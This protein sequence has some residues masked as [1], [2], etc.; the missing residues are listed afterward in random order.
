MDRLRALEARTSTMVEHLGAFVAAESPSADTEATAACAALVGSVGSELLG[1]EPTPHRVDGRTHLLWRFGSTTRVLLIGHLDTVWPLGT[2]DRWPYS[3]DDGRATGPGA[4]DMKSGI[5]QALHGLSTLADL[6]GLSLLITS[7]EEL[8]SQTSSSLI[9]ELAA[10]AEA[11][12]ILEPA[13][14]GALK[15]G[16]KGVSMYTIEIEGRA[17]HAGLEPEAGASAVVELAHQVLALGAIED[18]AA[19]TTVTPTVAS[20]GTAMNVVPANARV[21][22]DVRAPTVAEQDRV[23]RL[24][25]AL[26]PTVPGTTVRVLGEPNRPPL[27]QTSSS[28]L[29]AL[30]RRIASALG[31]GDL[32]G[33]TVGGGSDGNFTASM[34]CRTLDGLGGV[35]AGAHAEGEYVEVA[36]MAP[37]A[38]LLA[39]LA[40]ELLA[41]GP[42]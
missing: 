36:Q 39:A 28:D 18:R 2:I 27:E 10:G 4:F 14:D 41:E 15:T 24:M 16:R 13:S 29:F 35:G 40:E 19:G 7:D 6:D 9:R 12:L 1:A 17:A 26:K 30:A 8:G 31:I 38:A 42:R 34:G 22:V 5:V 33:V 23:H 32:R 21:H 11:S 37:R 3:V 20:A 25:Q